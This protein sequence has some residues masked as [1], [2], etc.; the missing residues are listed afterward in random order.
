[1]GT[2]TSST[3]GANDWACALHANKPAGQLQPLT[4]AIR[5][6]D[7]LANAITDIRSMVPGRAGTAELLERIRHDF[8]RQ[9]RPELYWAGKPE[10][11]RQ[12][13]N[14]LE[15][16]L[17]QMV[18]AEVKLPATERQLPTDTWQSAAAH[19]PHWA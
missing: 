13:V 8:D 9:G 19:M 10:T 16:V 7:W 2:M 12:W 5:R 14:R 11:V 6:F 4:A 17:E 3:S 1:M 15:P 18:L